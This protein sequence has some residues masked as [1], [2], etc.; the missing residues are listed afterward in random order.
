MHR[1]CVHLSL[2]QHSAALRSCRVL[3]IALQEKGASRSL[4]G[5]EDGQQVRNERFMGDKQSEWL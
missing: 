4:V 3:H 2:C 1:H 5:L